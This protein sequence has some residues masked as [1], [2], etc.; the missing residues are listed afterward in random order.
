MQE[1]ADLWMALRDRMKESWA[2]LTIQE[3][4]AG[5]WNLFQHI[6]T[7]RKRPQPPIPPASQAPEA[8]LA[9]V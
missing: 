7:T 6:F 9:T 2:D 3:K 5:E 8:S 4:K 1:Q